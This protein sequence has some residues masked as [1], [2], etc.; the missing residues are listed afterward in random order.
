MKKTHKMSR[1]GF[2]EFGI[3]WWGFEILEKYAIWIDCVGCLW[4]YSIQVLQIWSNTAKIV[5][6]FQ[7]YICSK[8]NNVLLPVCLDALFL[9]KD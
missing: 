9:K 2:D 5:N 3:E 1:T 7:L 8:Y 6:K 4:L